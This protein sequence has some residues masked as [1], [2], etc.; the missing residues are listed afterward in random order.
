M[1]PTPITPVQ[2]EALAATMAALSLPGDLRA[3]VLRMVNGSA[4]TADKLLTTRQA[5]AVLEHHP[6]TLLKLGR[7]GVI[8]PVR[9]SKRCIRWRESEIRRFAAEGVAP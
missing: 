9:R 3:R 1:N 5:A 8:S 2:V 6:K 4:D 7:M